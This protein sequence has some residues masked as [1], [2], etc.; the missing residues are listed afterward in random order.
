MEKPAVYRVD[1]RSP[2]AAAVRRRGAACPEVVTPSWLRHYW[3]FNVTLL[4][5]TVTETRV[6]EPAALTV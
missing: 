2:V 3:N 6:A 5:V 1:R 4:T